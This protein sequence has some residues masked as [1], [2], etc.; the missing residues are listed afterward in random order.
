MKIHTLSGYIQ[1]IYL[2]EH[3][4]GLLLLD[5]C[6]R[7]DVDSVSQF[8]TQD[9]KRPL[10]DL[11]LIV[12]THMH[13]DHAGGAA[14]LKALSGAPIAAHPKAVNWY[15]GFAGRTAHA[16]DLLLTWWVASR[17][18]KKR[19]SIWYNPVLNADILLEDEQHLPTFTDWKVL[20]SPGHTDHDLSVM[21][22]PTR[23]AYVAD[24]LVKVKGELVPPYPLCHPNQ[25]RSSLKRIAHSSIETLFCAHV[26]PIQLTEIPFDHVIENAPTLPKNHWHSTRNRINRKLF[27]QTKRH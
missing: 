12:V 11:K 27:G 26:A 13:P 7:A 8:I 3:E 23:Q 1:H 9:L 6:S 5:G 16:I 18:G 25:Y 24:L 10:S 20:Y 21:H 17:I 4:N 15:R 22:V 14:R 19:K 2:A